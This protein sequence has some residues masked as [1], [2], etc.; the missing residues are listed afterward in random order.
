MFLLDEF[1]Q[2]LGA[3]S[4]LKPEAFLD[5][6][7]CDLWKRWHEPHRYWH[8]PRHLFG[9]LEEAQSA[10]DSLRF[11]LILATAFHDAIY[12]PRRTDNEPLSARLFLSYA[13]MGSPSDEVAIVVAIEDTATGIARNPLSE[14]LLEMDR[15]IL[16]SSNLSELLAWENAI[17]REY[18]LH[19]WPDYVAGRCRFLRDHQLSNLA[20]YVESKR[21]RIGIYAGRFDPFHQGHLDILLRAEEL[22]DKVIVAV[23]IN[24]DKK[25]GS[26]EE[27]LNAV[28]ESL[29][30]HEVRG[31][32]GLLTDLVE[33]IGTY[34]D[35]SVVRGLRDG[36]DLQQEI[37]QARFL[38][39]L[40]PQA[41]TV[42]IPCDRRS[43]HISSTAIRA[44]RKFGSE[45]AVSYLPDRFRYAGSLGR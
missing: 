26:V 24:P 27:R 25:S 38:E 29:P 2:L 42:W 14:A 23:G 13:A 35:A 5:D 11:P 3:Q 36:Y 12:D 7:V 22:F 30:F 41:R 21:P 44:L 37:N 33:E 6:V 18:Q 32:G 20:G 34:A 19:P 40:S 28:R 16:G 43:Q 15:R 45:A 8:G 17:A 10:P 1:A 39:D 31:F 9:L 4:W